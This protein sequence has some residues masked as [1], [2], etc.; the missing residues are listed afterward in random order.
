MYK[1][2]EC[3]FTRNAIMFDDVNK[4]ITIIFIYVAVSPTISK[5]FTC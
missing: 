1:N 4:I 3:G 2:Q 5:T